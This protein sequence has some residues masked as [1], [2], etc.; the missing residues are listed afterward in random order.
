MGRSLAPPSFSSPPRRSFAL[1][2]EIW[3]NLHQHNNMQNVQKAKN[4]R[5]H[6]DRHPDFKYYDYGE[7]FTSARATMHSTLLQLQLDDDSETAPWPGVS[8]TV[9]SFVPQKNL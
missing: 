3:E 8:L 9:P 5:F 7:N 6:C 2:I 4:A 1:R